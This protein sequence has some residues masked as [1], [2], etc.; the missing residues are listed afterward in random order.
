MIFSSNL[1]FTS[2][3]WLEYSL[4]AF[5]PG[6]EDSE[7]P[8]QVRGEKLLPVGFLEEWAWKAGVTD[9]IHKREGFQILVQVQILKSQKLE[10]WKSVSN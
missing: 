4:L 7:E 6:K 9:Q 10:H 3:K 5:K 2:K 1:N 8:Q